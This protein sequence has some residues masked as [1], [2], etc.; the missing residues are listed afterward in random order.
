MFVKKNINR[1]KPIYR[2]RKKGN[3]FTNGYI[4]IN[5]FSFTSLSQISA[6]L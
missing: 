2:E 5:A 3:Q 1:T 6:A 4:H